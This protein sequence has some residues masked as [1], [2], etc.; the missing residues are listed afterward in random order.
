M[1]EVGG[2]CTCLGVEACVVG[3]EMDVNFRDIN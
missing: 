3:R 2:V 1:L